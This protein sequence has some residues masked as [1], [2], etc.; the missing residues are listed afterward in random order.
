MGH[1]IGLH[2]DSHFCN[3]SNKE[4]L[5]S[6]L[7]IEKRLLEEFFQTKINAFS[8][9]NNNNFTLNCEDWQYCGMINTYAKYFKTEIGYCSDSHGIWRFSSLLDILSN[10]EHSKLQVLTHPEWWQKQAMSPRERISRCID[11]RAS[12]CHVFYDKLLKNMG[13]PNIK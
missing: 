5:I 2:F 1:H 11:L 9:H 10:A 7:K 6:K 12:K 4:N 3:I 13:R 8:F